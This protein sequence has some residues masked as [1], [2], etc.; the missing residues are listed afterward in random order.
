M[1]ELIEKIVDTIK[2]ALNKIWIS[3]EDT[4]DNRDTN[5]IYDFDIYR[6]KNNPNKTLKIN[7]L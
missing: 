7:K 1:N 2:P 5:T 4:F 6:Y 3:E